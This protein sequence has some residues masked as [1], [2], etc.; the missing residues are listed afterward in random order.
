M[1]PESGLGITMNRLHHPK[2]VSPQDIRKSCPC[3]YRSVIL[4][5]IRQEL[6]RR[7]TSGMKLSLSVTSDWIGRHYV[8]LDISGIWDN[9]LGH[10]GPKIGLF[11]PKTGLLRPK[12]GQKNG[13]FGPKIGLFGHFW[14]ILDKK[15]AFPGK[16]GK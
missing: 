13:L 1:S 15:S 5:D 2:S 12:I 8:Y 6:S 10:F 14:D 16:T 3:G 9:I 7:V 4:S 11:G